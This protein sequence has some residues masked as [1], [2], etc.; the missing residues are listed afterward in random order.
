MCRWLAYYGSP[1]PIDAIL[2]RPQDSLIGLSLQAYRGAWTTDGRGWCI[3]W[4]GVGY[5]PGVC[6]GIEPAW[7]DRILRA[8]AQHLMTPL[9]FEHVR[10]SSGIA[11]QQTDCHPV[12][13]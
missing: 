4:Y 12:R 3:G 8:L 10:A 13:H 2:Y 11:V 1:I 7:N 6:H 5:T 9:V